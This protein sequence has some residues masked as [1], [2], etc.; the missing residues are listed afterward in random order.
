MNGIKLLS[1]VFAIGDIPTRS[2][3]SSAA[4]AEGI[5]CIEKIKGLDIER[6][7]YEYSRL[8]LL[9]TRDCIGRTYGKASNREGYEI[10]VGKFFIFC[11]W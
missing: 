9:Y 4:S 7:D 6:I 10:K 1:E 8:Y 3:G 5:I 2:V 11:Q